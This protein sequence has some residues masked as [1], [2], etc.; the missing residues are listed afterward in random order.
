MPNN[1]Q[2]AFLFWMLVVAAVVVCRK[3]TRSSV[4]G[5]LRLLVSPKLLTPILAFVG[6]VVALVAIAGRLGLWDLDLTADTVMWLLTA[7]AVLFGSLDKASAENHFVRRRAFETF[8]ASAFV[9]VLA[10]VFVLKLFAEVVLLPVFAFLGGISVVA[11]QKKEHRPVKKFVDFV[12][13]AGG[14]ALLLY[15]TVSLIDNWGAL[16][17]SHLLRQFAMP[18]WLTIGVLP[19]IYLLGVWAAY[20]NAFIRVNWRSEAGWRGRTRAKLVLL[21]SFGLSAR[22]VGSFGGP[23]QFKLAEAHSFRAGR[24]VIRDFRDAQAQEAREAADAADRLVRFAGVDGVDDEGRQ[25]DRREFDETT[26]ALLWLGTCHMGWYD[27]QDRYKP[28]LFELLEV[29]FV[30][31]G[32]PEEHGIEQRISKAGKKWFAWRRNVT[33]C[34]PSARQMR[35]RISGSTTVPNRQLASHE[36]ILSGASVRSSST[37]V[38]IGDLPRPRRRRRPEGLLD[39]VTNGT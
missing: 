34:S 38:G 32:L 17:K 28:D 7:G 20:E 5:A 19:Y 31:R 2:W 29:D 22:G 37:D 23:W 13:A 11:D 35:L 16:D 15:V 10:E 33:G 4:G 3:E 12:I 1:R 24:Q 14:W 6:L 30:R 27:R 39:V 36:K 26:S 8:R 25:L 21:R 18:M 9:E